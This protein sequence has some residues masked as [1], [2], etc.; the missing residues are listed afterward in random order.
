MSCP[1][2]RFASYY[3]NYYSRVVAHPRVLEWHD[4]GTNP[5]SGI[6][7]EEDELDDMDNDEAMA[8]YYDMA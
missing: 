5:Q 1:Q 8:A 6:P 7:F 3:D 4:Q 2:I